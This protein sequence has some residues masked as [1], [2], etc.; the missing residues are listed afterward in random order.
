[1]TKN[2]VI[3]GVAAIGNEGIKKHFKNAETWQP[4]FELVW[5]GFDAAATSVSV[6]LVENS[7]H[8]VER[9]IVKDDGCGIDFNT[10]NDTFGSFNDSAKKVNLALKGAHG[11]GRL[12]FHLLCHNASWFTRSNSVDAV[13]DVDAASIKEF[14]GRPLEIQQQREELIAQGR[15]TLVELTHFTSSLPAIA[16]LREKFSVEFGWYL[17]VNS[18][19]KLLL[20]GIPVVVPAHE[21]VRKSIEVDDAIFEAQ[22]IRWERRPTS[23][24]SFLYLMNSSGEL[25]YKVHSSLNQKPNFFTSVCVTSEWADTFSKER[26]LLKPDAHTPTSRTWRKFQAQLDELN[27]GVYDEF[28]RRRAEEVVQGYE[29]DG[30]FPTYVGLDESEKAWRH[31]HAR[32]MVRQIYI[33]DPRV[34]HNANKKQTKI[35]IRLLDRLAVSNENDAL[36]DLLNDALDLDAASMEK[37]A[38]QLRRSSLENVIAS[39]EILQRR[40]AAVQQIRYIMNEHYREVLETPDLQQIIESNTWLFGPR[41]ETIGAEEDSF[42]KIVKR[43]REDV[44]ARSKVN[45][46]DVA[47]DEDLAGANRQSDLFLA[48][49]FPTFDSSGQQVFKCIV[50]E[51]KRPAI[52]LNKKHLRQLEDYADIIKRYPEFKSEK[53]HFELILLGRQISSA[54]TQ[55]PS[56]LNSLIARGEP[57]LVADDPRMKLYVLNWYSL[58]DGFELTNGFMLDNLKLKRDDYSALS[59]EE[60]VVQLQTKH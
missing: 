38:N 54:D 20:N 39:I 33:A 16:D 57:G 60:L 45:E 14:V 22:V 50:V 9:V 43:L 44:M 25:V 15:G 53:M 1:M 12:A 46:E 24:K 26:D 41:Y 23:E 52:S 28:L 58:L 17:A 34:F 10:L 4:L 42:T 3:K 47:D 59:K 2:S 11:R 29:Q 19:R 6:D 32:E 51:I 49:K 8:G 48:R 7:M 5:N 40:T 31:Q 35:I 30:Y 21:A 13:I 56:R 18:E 55:I 36:L 37:L 27:Q